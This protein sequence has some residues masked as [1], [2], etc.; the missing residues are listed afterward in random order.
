MV[1]VDRSCFHLQY[2]KFF[3]IFK[4]GPWLFKP[5]KAVLSG[6]RTHETCLNRKASDPQMLNP[7]PVQYDYLKRAAHPF[8]DVKM[9]LLISCFCLGI[10]TNHV[11]NSDTTQHNTSG[12]RN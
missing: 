8:F 3:C 10:G 7:N 11:G 6:L 4:K 12:N 1:S 9:E 2:R 5:Q